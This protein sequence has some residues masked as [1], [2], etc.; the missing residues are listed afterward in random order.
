MTIAVNDII[1]IQ[2]R[3]L[4]NGVDA[5]QN[6]W[7]VRHESGVVA[8]DAVWVAQVAALID[9]E[10]L[11]YAAGMSTNITPLDLLFFNIT[12]DVTLPD[13]AWV[14]FL[15]GTA[16]EEANAPQVS[17]EVYWRTAAAR[18]VGRK[19]L[20]PST[21]NH[22]NDGIWDAGL[23]ALLLTFALNFVG[24]RVIGLG[25]VSFGTFNKLLAIYNAYKTAFVPIDA[26][27][28]RRRR[29]GVGS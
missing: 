26:R 15:G 9:Q 1:R 29:T 2:S 14:T 5:V 24:L 22:N 21:E 12:Q 11:A 10:F 17:C 7:H 25:Q 8:D 28:Q 4:R 16:P 6:V 19:F 3:M 13:G 23:L 27:T 18:V 20:P